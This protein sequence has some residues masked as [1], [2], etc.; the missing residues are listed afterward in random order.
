MDILEM[1]SD[2][3]LTINMSRAAELECETPTRDVMP[4]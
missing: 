2:G 4:P 1:I 3:Y